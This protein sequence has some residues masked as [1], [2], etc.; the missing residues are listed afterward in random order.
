MSAVKT[1]LLMIASAI[2]GVVVFVIG[3]LGWLTY[4]VNSGEGLP[5]VSWSTGGR[6]AERG[7]TTVA[8]PPEIKQRFLG[9][10]GTYSGGFSADRNKVLAAGPG[11]IAGT[12]RIDEKPATGLKLRL[13]LNGA[14]M[15]QWSEVDA[16]G[17]Y[18]IAVPYGSYRIDGYDLDG[19]TANAVLAGKTDGPENN[20][21]GDGDTFT[22]AAGHAGAGP[23]LRYV[24]PIVKIGPKGTVSASKPVVVQW[25]P[26]PKA[27]SYRVQLTGR[28]GE[29]DYSNHVQAFKWPDR[30]VVTGT[31]FDIAEHGVKLKTGYVYTVEITA[32]DAEGRT[33]V[34][35]SHGLRSDFK[36]VE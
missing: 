30:P 13:A 18:A 27:A 14:V 19:R 6:P 12:V 26:Y 33:I 22:V 4:R 20:G 15:S 23:D 35:S 28:P 3:A 36:V 2:M 5:S 8:V 7:E 34:D 9:V 32:L 10:Y 25:R 16:E 31:S 29:N 24:D 11:A 21:R 17:R 1:V